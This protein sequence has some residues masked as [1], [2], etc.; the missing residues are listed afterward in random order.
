MRINDIPYLDLSSPDRKYIAA[1]LEFA[2]CSVLE[3]RIWWSE[4]LNTGQGDILR[5]A[6]FVIADRIMSQNSTAVVVMV[7]V[8]GVVPWCVN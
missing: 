3:Q 2:L 6:V 7:A 5:T 4:D 1:T 8:F